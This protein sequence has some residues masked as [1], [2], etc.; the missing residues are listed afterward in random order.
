MGLLV[1]LISAA[2]CALFYIRMVRRETPEPMP[3]KQA[4]TPVV[5]GLFAP[6]LSTALTLL[7]AL[8]VIAMTGG[9]KLPDIIQNLLLSSLVS[10]FLKAGFTEELVKFLLLLAIVKRQKPKNVYEYAVLAAGIGFGFTV[11]ERRSP[12]EAA[13]WQRRYCAC[14]ALRCIWCSA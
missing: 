4:A 7:I 6:I 13:I 2:L 3:R 11:L 10:S 9:R 1:A 14:H 5:A 8:A 12:M